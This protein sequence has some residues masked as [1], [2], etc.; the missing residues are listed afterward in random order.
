[1]PDKESK[2]LRRR[3]AEHRA[4]M[5]RTLVGIKETAEA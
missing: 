2:I 4:N 1:M 3:L 5:E